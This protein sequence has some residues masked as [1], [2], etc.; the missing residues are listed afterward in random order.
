M[1]ATESLKVPW[2]PWI[3]KKK[4]FY[5]WVIVAV[6]GLTQFTQGIVSQGFATY[7]SPL[8]K[9]F[10]WSRAVLAGP[11]SVTQVENAIFGPIGGLLVDKLGPRIM[12]AIGTFTMGMGLILFGLTH[13][14]FMYYLAN[15]IIAIGT[16]FQGLL[17]MS[18]A[19]NHWFRRKR[20]IAQSIMLIGFAMAGVIGVPAL[21][22]IQT[23]LGWRTAAVGTGLLVWAVGIPSSMLLRRTPEPYG[24]LPDGNVSGVTASAGTG[25]RRPIE[26]YDFT[27]REAIRTRSFWLFALGN[28]VGNL[29]MGAVM[30]HLF[31]HLEQ[32]VGLSRT[33]AAFVWT[34]A[35][36]TNIPSRLAGGFLGDRLPKNLILGGAMAMMALSQ[37]VL[38]SA[39]SLP[40][41]MTY[42]VLYGIGWGVRTPVM[43]AMQGEYFGR[44]SLGI[45][46]GS[47][48]SLGLP[49]T[50]AAPVVAGYMADTY[51][52]YRL[53]FIVMSFVTLLGGILIVLATH[54]KP[55]VQKKAAP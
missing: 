41:A 7:L 44:R 15:V 28:A 19:I 27:F 33:T 26:E 29:G 6:G 51:G 13:S 20:T 47:L 54:P 35:S 46:S 17:V 34:V 23:R 39:T 8:Q 38:G 36:M 55:P 9:E 31:L 48:Q 30:V 10:G 43:N 14:L 45:I 12:V 3:G 5:G 16:G 1:S 18:V 40:M 53:T 21:V 50:I 49:I 37:F 11:S 24:L 52:T 32:G 4:P 25:G 42:A 22:F 2:F